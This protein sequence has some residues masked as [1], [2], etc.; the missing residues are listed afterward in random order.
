[1]LGV[2]RHILSNFLKNIVLFRS[3]TEDSKDFNI[4][5]LKIYD[6]V[7]DDTITQIQNL[8]GV[9]RVQRENYWEQVEEKI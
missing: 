6:Q 8:E 1:M 5:F 4:E 3:D 7:M 2:T 9:K